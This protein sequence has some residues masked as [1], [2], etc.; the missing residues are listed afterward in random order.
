MMATKQFAVSG[1]DEVEFR[2]VGQLILEQGG[3]ESLAADGRDEALDKI[4]AEVVAGRLKLGFEH[5]WFEFWKLAEYRDTKFRVGVK[6]IRAVILSGSGDITSGKLAGDA[7]R[8]ELNGSGNVTLAVETK[9]FESRLAGAGNIRVSGAADV[10]R[11]EIDGSGSVMAR[12]LNAKT[13]EVTIRGSGNVEVAAS[14]SLS[15]SIMGH[16]NVRYTGNPKLDQRVLGTG[17]IE[18][19]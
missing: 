14:D 4:K 3:T 12:E 17:R 13:A 10:L 16:G 15:I 2:G 1:F 18:R 8:I 7:L 11:T 19:V 6:S 9:R 5:N